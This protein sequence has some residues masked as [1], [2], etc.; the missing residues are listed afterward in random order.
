MNEAHRATGARFSWERA[1]YPPPWVAA[2]PRERGHAGNPLG[3]VRSQE[4]G[5]QGGDS[6]S[7]GGTGGRNPGHRTVDPAGHPDRR[8]RHGGKLPECG[9]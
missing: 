2:R 5:G 9:P 6:G 1:G 7:E 4:E 3:V 8:P